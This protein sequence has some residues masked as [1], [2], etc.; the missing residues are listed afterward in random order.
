MGRQQRIS[1][2]RGGRRCWVRGAKVRGKDSFRE[3]GSSGFPEVEGEIV[4]GEE[5]ISEP[6]FELFKYWF[7][8]DIL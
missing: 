4:L 1:G 7:R 6:S 2:R 3:I 5:K 8:L